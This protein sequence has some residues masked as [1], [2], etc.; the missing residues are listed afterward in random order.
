MIASKN[1][2]GYFGA[3]DTKFIVGNWNTKTFEL[4]W[5]EK[6]DL[7]HNK[8]SNKYLSAGTNYE[9]KIIDSLEIEGI[10]KDRQII[11]EKYKLRVNLDSNTEDTIYEVKTYSYEKEFKVSNDYKNQVIVQMYADKKRKAFIVAYGL[12]E[13]DYKNFF[14][15]IDQNRIS[16]HEITYDEEFIK[17]EYLPKLKYLSECLIKGKIPNEEE[18]E[19]KKVNKKEE[20]EK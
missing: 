9:H 17:K 4:W 3:S 8:L 19:T 12:I 15:D 18:F 14:N 5:L 2:S 11:I 20:K 13:K 1:R 10:V 16:F 7:Y 6:L